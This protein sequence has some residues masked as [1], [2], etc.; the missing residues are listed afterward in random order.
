MNKTYKFLAAFIF[1]ASSSNVLAFYGGGQAGAMKSCEPPQLDKFTPAHLSVVI[2]QSEFSFVASKKIS[3]ESIVVSAKKQAVEVT[4]DQTED[5]YIVSG[6]LP[7]SLNNTY[8]RIEIKATTAAGCKG[9][10]GWLLNIREEEKLS[11]TDIESAVPI[12][13]ED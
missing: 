7:S 12:L 2:P 8:A 1:V 5:G 13:S 4:I 6:K 9:N 3:P 11:E 10:K